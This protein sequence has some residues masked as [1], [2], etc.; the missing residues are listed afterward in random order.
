MRKLINSPLSFGHE[1]RL[2]RI[3]ANSS[4]LRKQ[5]RFSHYRYLVEIYDIFY[6]LKEQSKA[7]KAALELARQASFNVRRDHHP[8]RI[9][10]ELST[11]IQDPKIIS[12]WTRA[13]E[14]ADLRQISSDNL[15]RF[16]RKR[17]GIAG[18]AKRAA[19]LLPK[20]DQGAEEN[21]YS[22]DEFDDDC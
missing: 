2:K 16:L 15:E 9:L 22:E 7:R 14:Y 12:R 6:E 17:G 21:S 5:D 8:L 3:K 13:L 11:S 1:R 18:C 4:R 20:R 19:E 10:I